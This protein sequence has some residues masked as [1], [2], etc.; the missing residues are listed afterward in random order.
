[1][2]SVQDRDVLELQTKK[3]KDVVAIKK[4]LWTCCW[5][6]NC[7]RLTQTIWAVMALSGSERLEVGAHPR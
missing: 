1:M 5:R 4:R 7:G 3:T 2:P 6:C